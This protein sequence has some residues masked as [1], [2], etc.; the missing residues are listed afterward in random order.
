M[1]V[2]TRVG[3]EKQ[4]PRFALNDNEVFVAKGEFMSSFMKKL[5]ESSALLL[6][7]A[8][9]SV[10]VMAQDGVKPEASPEVDMTW[11]VKIPVRDGAKLNATIYQPHAQKEPL[12]LLFTFTP[13]IGDSYRDRAMYF[14]WHGFVYGLV[15]GRGRGSSEGEFE[16]FANEG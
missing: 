14:A 11:G 8:F 9:I 6:A 16:P 4:I 2:T 5:V 3:E 7:A 1:R 15:D 10:G 12:P 13:Y